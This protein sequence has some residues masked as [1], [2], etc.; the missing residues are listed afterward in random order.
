[1]IKNNFVCY[2]E[3]LK[4]DKKL[5]KES[6]LYAYINDKLY[7]GPIIDN[8]FNYNNLIKRLKAS[9]LYNPYKIKKMNIDNVISNYIKYSSDLSGDLIFVIQNNEL[10]KEYKL[11]NIPGDDYE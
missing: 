6:V 5:A 3:I 10:L 1:M 2:S 8:K 11:R 4:N 7:L 9:A